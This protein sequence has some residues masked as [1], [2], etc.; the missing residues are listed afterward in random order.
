MIFYELN[1]G[2]PGI[3]AETFITY[4]SRRNIEVEPSPPEKKTEATFYIPRDTHRKKKH[5]SL[6]YLNAAQ[7][8]RDQRRHGGARAAA[9]RGA[10]L[11]RLWR[12]SDLAR[13]TRL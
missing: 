7:P 3:V 8:R 2:I 13:T 9:A 5:H 6:R 1:R 10:A 4:Q 12:G 11:T